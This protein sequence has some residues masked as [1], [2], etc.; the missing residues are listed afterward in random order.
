MMKLCPFAY[1]FGKVDIH[2]NNCEFNFNENAKQ[3]IDG[4]SCPT[5]GSVIEFKDCVFTGAENIIG[6]SNYH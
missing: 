5:N 1:S 4:Y 2:F 6:Y 3:L